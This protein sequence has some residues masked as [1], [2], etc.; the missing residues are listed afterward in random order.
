MVTKKKL[1]GQNIID[2]ASFEDCYFLS[3][4]Q[5]YIHAKNDSYNELAKKLRKLEEKE[6]NNDK[7][8]FSEEFNELAHKALI[9]LDETRACLEGLILLAEKSLETSDALFEKMIRKFCK[10]EYVDIIIGLKFHYY[11]ETNKWLP[12]KS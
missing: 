2:R 1:D 3:K 12:R 9:A 4:T 10:P 11:Q 5:D 6:L 8:E 7:E